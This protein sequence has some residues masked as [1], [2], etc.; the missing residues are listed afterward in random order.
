MLNLRRFHSASWSLVDQATVSLGTFLV[1]IILAR[2]LSPHDYGL[3]TILFGAIF[4]VQTVSGS[5]VFYPLSVRGG[6]ADG[7]ERMAI[8]LNAVILGTVLA[9]VMALVLATFANTFLDYRLV[10]CAP[11]FYMAR[12]IQ[13]TLRRSLFTQFRYS[14]ALIG[15]IISYIGPCILL[16]YLTGRFEVSLEIAFYAMALTSCLA[17]IVQLIQGAVSWSGS[18][19]LRKVAGEFWHL[20]KWSFTSNVASRVQEQILPFLLAITSGPSATAGLQASLNITN[21]SNPI[22]AGLANVIPQTTAR[23]S[24]R[25]MVEA[26]RAAYPLILFGSPPILLLLVT[27]LYMPESILALAYGG[28]P[29][30]LQLGDAIRLLAIATALNYATLAGSAFLF[31]ADAGYQVHHIEIVGTFIAIVAAAL[32]VPLYGLIGSCLALVIT[33]LSRSI[34]VYR[35]I[36][37]LVSKP[38]SENDARQKMAD[39]TVGIGHSA[40]S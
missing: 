22:M 10:F 32:L 11:A 16:I 17:I 27:L 14:A 21:V 15:D 33:N 37:H 3:F 2:H 7:E 6:A 12:Q 20:G 1:N 23:A 28:E 4:L 38:V 40:G 29:H 36:F 25:G 24:E 9:I 35:Q 18:L 5:L 30:Y 34:L 31:G 13:E 19:Q 26:W 39:N 8:I